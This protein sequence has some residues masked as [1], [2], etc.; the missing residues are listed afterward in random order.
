MS[1]PDKATLTVVGAACVF[2]CLPLLVAAGPVVVVGGAVAAVAG[3]AA[4]LARRTKRTRADVPQQDDRQAQV[5]HPDDEDA[6]SRAGDPIP[7][8][9]RGRP[10]S[11]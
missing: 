5:A 10:I 8:V 4:H 11:P 9:E 3:G 1:G 6:E 2:C 7:A